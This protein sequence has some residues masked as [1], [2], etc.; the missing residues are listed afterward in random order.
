MAVTEIKL[1]NI[2]APTFQKVWKLIKSGKYTEYWL[3]GGRASTKSSFISLALV[4]LIISDPKANC[5]CFRKVENTLATSVFEQIL[6]AI[7]KLHLNKF[8]KA[9]VSPMAITYLPTGQKILFRGLDDPRRIKSLKSYKGYFKLAWFEELDEFGGMEEIR[10]VTQS[11]MR[12]GD[13]FIYFYS[14]NPPNTTANWVNQ[15]ATFPKDTRYVHHSTYL[16]VP[17]EWLGK[18][19]FLE[20]EHLKKQDELAYRHEYLGEACGNGKQIFRNVEARVLTPQE[21]AD[22]DN[23]R[24]GVDWGY[25]TS[26]FAFVKLHYDITRR[27]IYIFDEIYEAGLLN[28]QAAARVKSIYNIGTTVYA[29]SAEPKSIAD[30][31]SRGIFTRPAVKGPDSRKF[32]IKWLQNLDKI[33]IDPNRCPNALKEFTLMELEKDRAGN[34]KDEPP[35][36]NDHCIDAVRYSLTNDMVKRGI[37]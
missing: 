25:V 30:F 9:T 28:E 26:A 23:L 29:D 21:M 13:S 34:W 6:W 19:L 3:K 31:N 1:S 16:D 17:K 24:Q 15:E 2:F 14:Y 36:V 20:A 10:K 27:A 4:L 33:Y 18:D 37:L 8:F 35:K 11:L 7:E 22:F 5:V 12:G 32:G